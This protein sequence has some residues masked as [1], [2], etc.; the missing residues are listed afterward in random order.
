VANSE[1]KMS[2]GIGRRLAKDGFI[3]I[4]AEERGTYCWV[5]IQVDMIPTLS[6]GNSEVGKYPKQI[7]ASSFFHYW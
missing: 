1:R 5:T 6:C 3:R 4:K 2:G 7:P